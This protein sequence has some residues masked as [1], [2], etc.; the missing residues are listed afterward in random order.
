M[1]H[2]GR[3]ESWVCHCSPARLSGV[4]RRRG[5]RSFH[6]GGTYFERRGCMLEPVMCC[7]ASVSV[8]AAL[9]QLDACRLRIGSEQSVSGSTQ[10][11]EQTR[12]GRRGGTA[13][14]KD[15]VGMHT[16]E[17]RPGPWSTA[18]DLQRQHSRPPWAQDAGSLRARRRT[19]AASRADSQI[20][21]RPSP[22]RCETPGGD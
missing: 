1:R 6:T 10:H 18:S 12:L 13:M 4:D 7:N 17:T 3:V 22:A 9:V 2:T 14:M 11:A 8:L 15:L 21:D 19:G 16:A 5:S 20:A